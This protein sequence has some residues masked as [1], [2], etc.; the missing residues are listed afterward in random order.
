MPLSDEEYRLKRRAEWNEAGKRYA[1]LSV[2]ALADL[3]RQAAEQVFKL[4]DLQPGER[5][6]D[7]GTGAGSPALEAAPFVGPTG[8]IVGID[9]AASMIESARRRAEEL[10][11][12]N[13]EFFEQEGE[14]LDFP[15]ESFDA[16]ISRYAYPHFTNASAAFKESYRVLRKGGRLGASMHGAVELNPYICAPIM[17]MSKYHLNPSPL[18]ARGP[19]AL[20][21]PALLEAELKKAGFSDVRA[22]AFDTLI[23]VDDFTY[24][25]ETQKQGGASIRRALDAVP[26]EKRAE[27]E[28]AAL[29]SMER[30]VFNNRGEFPAQIIAGTGVKG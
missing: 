2:G 1:N 10:G 3:S 14:H 26:E 18:T 12:G 21:T 29:A 15:D 7:V 17:V 20:H 30:Y 25:W 4:V 19:F 13:A 9:S 23:V 11:I 8:R 22:I 27:A 16:I 5:V 24:Y 28:K 6:L